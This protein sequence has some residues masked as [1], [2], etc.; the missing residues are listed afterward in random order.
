MT[1]EL[2]LRLRFCCNDGGQKTCKL[3]LPRFRLRPKVCKHWRRM[4]ETLH[5]LSVAIV[6]MLVKWSSFD[7][8]FF[9]RRMDESEV[10]RRR[11]HQKVLMGEIEAPTLMVKIPV[12][13][14]PPGMAGTQVAWP[15]WKRTCFCHEGFWL[16]FVNNTFISKHIMAMFSQY[17]CEEV[18]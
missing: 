16:F 3:I 14:F 11:G 15:I 1:S 4:M 5:M 17:C 13:W 2:R 9:Q 18:V 6:T 10:F 8:S 7:H 12:H